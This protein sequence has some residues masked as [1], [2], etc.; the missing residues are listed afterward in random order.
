MRALAVRLR[1][2]NIREKV[3]VTDWPEPEG[4]KGNQIKTQT[5]YSGITNGTERNNLIRG[6]YAA[7]DKALPVVDGYQNV[8]RVIEVGPEVKTLSVG[9]VLYMSIRHMEYEVSSED[10]LL[11]KLPD[12]VDPKQAALF[13]VSGVAMR[14]CRNA[15]IRMGERVLVIGAGIVGQTAA[16]IATAM[17]AR[18]TICDIDDRRLE[19]AKQIGVVEEALNVSGDGW[20]QN[21]PNGAFDVLMDVA[22]VPGMEDKLIAAA[23]QRGRVM[24][25]AGRS[26]VNYNF[27]Q[28]QGREITIKQ[29]SHFDRNDI[30]NLCRLVTRGIVKIGSLIRDVVPVSEAGRIYDKLRDTP[31][32][33]HGTVFVW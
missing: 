8:G 14:T 7:P 32:K 9:D 30:E 12:A 16:Q 33:L 6:N 1:S 20:E 2:D 25:I 27:N 15:D 31:D 28:G 19:T 3:L 18:T 26:Q 23:R 10:S 21:I 13:G 22:G 29:N 11:I 5:I 4:P 17:G 24:F